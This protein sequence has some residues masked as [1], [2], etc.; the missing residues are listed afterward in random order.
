MAKRGRH[1]G[2]EENVEAGGLRRH[3][4]P[5]KRTEGEG[6]ASRGGGGAAEWRKA[7]EEGS[8]RANGAT[9]KP[10]RSTMYDGGVAQREGQGRGGGN[11]SFPSHGVMAR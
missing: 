6:K 11:S 7:S 4:G 1:G 10:T 3:C 8:A 5:E 2:A 9:A